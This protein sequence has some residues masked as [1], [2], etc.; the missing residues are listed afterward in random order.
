MREDAKIQTEANVF[1]Y[2]LKSS[3]SL[4]CARKSYFSFHLLVMRLEKDDRA[5][6]KRANRHSSEY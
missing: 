2:S 1:S 5:E 3:Y 6:I 4:I